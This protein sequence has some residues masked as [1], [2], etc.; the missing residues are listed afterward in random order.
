MPICFFHLNSTFFQQK[1]PPLLLPRRSTYRLVLCKHLINKLL[2]YKEELKVAA[3]SPLLDLVLS[4]WK[5]E[6]SVYIPAPKISHVTSVYLEG[7]M[8]L[9]WHIIQLRLICFTN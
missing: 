8:Q 4:F 9:H 7:H 3:A 2:L 5:L 1:P 6:M